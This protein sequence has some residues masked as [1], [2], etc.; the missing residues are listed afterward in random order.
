MAS[1]SREEGGGGEETIFSLSG[2][3]E[4]LGKEETGTPQIPGR[5]GAEGTGNHGN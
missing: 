3:G 2:T 4:G 1:S 5:A